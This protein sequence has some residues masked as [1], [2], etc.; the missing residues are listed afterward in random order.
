M[1]D[2]ESRPGWKRWLRPGRAYLDNLSAPS[3]ALAQLLEELDDLDEYDRDRIFLARRALSIREP[4][5]LR[6]NG[7]RKVHLA[8]EADIRRIWTTYH[9]DTPI[10][11]L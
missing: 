4:V 11:E 3:R 7:V 5:L 9:P 2:P 8:A 6:S 10:E 1:S